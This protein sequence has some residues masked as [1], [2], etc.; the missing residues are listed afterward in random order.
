MNYIRKSKQFALSF[1][2]CILFA[3]TL[4][5]PAYAADKP[6][7]MSPQAKPVEHDPKVFGPDPSYP[8]K[9]YDAPGQIDIYGGKS[10]FD[11]V[12]PILE[13]GRPIYLEGPF[14]KG[15]NILGRKNAIY[16]GFHVYGDWRTAVGYNDNGAVETGLVATRLN[17]ELDLRL[18]GT[19]RIHATMTPLNQGGNFT[20]FK[21]SGDDGDDDFEL[22][23]NLNL[24][25]LFF[26]GD[27]GTITQGLS[28]S[29]NLIDLPFS[30]GLMPLLFQNGVWFEDAIVGGAFAIPAMSSP[31]YGI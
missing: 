7:E 21:F 31:K 18:T 10:R 12:R 23:N 17:L 9:K 19:E 2:M 1:V 5:M 3:S 4:V 16:P 6:S 11:E 22:R 14:E 30:F 25:A 27:V 8:E 13:L 20:Q 28:D 29:Y 24:D 26:E 15:I